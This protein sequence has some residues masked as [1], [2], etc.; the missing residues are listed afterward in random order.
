MSLFSFFSVPVGFLQSQYPKRLTQMLAM[1]LLLIEPW[2]GH[3]V[4]L[5]PHPTGYWRKGA[6]WSTDADAEARGSGRQV[7]GSP[8]QWGRKAWLPPKGCGNEHYRCCPSQRSLCIILLSVIVEFR[9]FST[10]EVAPGT[11]QKIRQ[12]FLGN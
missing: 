4:S 12:Y 10:N 11:S 8:A 5:L 9:C 2:K 3:L 1:Q 7:L 6:Q